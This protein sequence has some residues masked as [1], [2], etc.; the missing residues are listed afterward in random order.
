MAY[1]NDRKEWGLWGV[2]VSAHYT[3]TTAIQTATSAS[4]LRDAALCMEF[5]PLATRSSNTWVIWLHCYGKS[6]VLGNWESHRTKWVIFVKYCEITTCDLPSFCLIEMIPTS[7]RR[8]KAS[9]PCGFAIPSF[10]RVATTCLASCWL[11]KQVSMD[12]FRENLQE[13]MVLPWHIGFPVKF[14]IIQFC[15]SNP[16]RTVMGANLLETIDALWLSL[17]TILKDH[18]MSRRYCES[19]TSCV[20]F[21]CKV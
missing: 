21:L 12:W 19:S 1:Q 5:I 8:R 11:P 15:D 17:S 20:Y 16:Q 2:S 10:L 14:P 18:R 6:P 4:D 9:R 7:Q 13:T 3:T